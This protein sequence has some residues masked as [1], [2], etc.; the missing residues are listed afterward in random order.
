MAI[1]PFSHT[2]FDYLTHDDLEGCKTVVDDDH[3]YLMI[4]LSRENSHHTVHWAAN[5]VHGLKASLCALKQNIQISF[6]PDEWK[7]TLIESG[8]RIEAELN[9]FWRWDM[10]GCDVWKA[11]CRPIEPAEVTVISAISETCAGQS[12]GFTARESDEYVS[13]IS[14]QNPQAIAA[15]A[16]DA[17]I[18]VRRDGSDIVGYVCVACYGELEKKTLWIREIAVA[19]DK[20]HQGHGRMLFESALAYGCGHGVSRAFLMADVQNDPALRLYADYG[21]RRREGE[22]ET[23]MTYEPDQT[24]SQA[25]RAD[26]ARN[27]SL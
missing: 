5:D 1:K 22:S 14:G 8:F 10:H 23:V 19:P 13:W 16:T 2:S 4:D 9:D 18:L 3:A 26:H 17:Q 12:R 25:G 21:F 24:N 20:Q 11:S 6:V 27:K 7:E 15:G